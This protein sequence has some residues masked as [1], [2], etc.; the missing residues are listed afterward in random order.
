MPIRQ[1]LVAPLVVILAAGL[2]AGCAREKYETVDTALGSEDRALINVTM[3]DTLER[4]QVGQG[5]NW[6]NKPTKRRGCAVPSG[7]S[8]AC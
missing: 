6:T 3:Q 8:P 2:L 1:S 4:N 5:S 7:S